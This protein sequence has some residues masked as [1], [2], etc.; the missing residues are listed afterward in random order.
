MAR[1]LSPYFAIAFLFGAFVNY[2]MALDLGL[3]APVDVLE[4]RHVRDVN[5]GTDRMKATMNV[6]LIKP[7]LKSKKSSWTGPRYGQTVKGMKHVIIMNDIPRT[8]GRLLYKAALGAFE[9]NWT[10]VADHLIQIEKQKKNIEEVEKLKPPTLVHGHTSFHPYT[11]VW[12]NP[13]IYINFVREPVARMESSFYY[14]RFG[15]YAQDPSI[16]HNDN[17]TLEKCVKKGL[18]WCGPWWN[19]HILFCGYDSK[20]ETD[21]E[22]SLEKAKENIDKYYTFVGITEEFETSLQIIELLVPDLLG[23][24]FKAYKDLNDVGINWNDLFRTRNKKRLS[25]RLENKAREIMKDDVELYDYAY[26]KF[27]QLKVRFGLE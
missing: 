16:H 22:W 24:L 15:D 7:T 18:V 13:P 12:E 9:Y 10:T 1:C 14:E 17:M 6:T 25:H 23:G 8:A 26:D 3:F 2:F 11:D 4:E 20:C 19:W 21:H 5:P 27:N